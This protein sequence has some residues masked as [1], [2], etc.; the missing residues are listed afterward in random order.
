MIVKCDYVNYCCSDVYYFV[1]RYSLK[2]LKFGKIDVSR[3]PLVAEKY[4]VCVLVCVKEKERGSSM[5]SFHCVS[6]LHL[7]L[8]L[9]VCE[10]WLCLF[11]S[12]CVFCVLMCWLC[13]MLLSSHMYVTVWCRFAVYVIQTAWCVCFV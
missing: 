4:A 10:G 3:Y 2:N 13:L 11:S 6:C 1:C 7:S 12:S 9:P 8:C 5:S